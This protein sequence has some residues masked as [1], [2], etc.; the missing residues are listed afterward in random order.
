MFLIYLCY[1]YKLK[2]AF[3]NAQNS[4]EYS[5]RLLGIV[6]VMGANVGLSCFIRLLVAFDSKYS[7]IFRLIGPILFLIQLVV[8]MSPFLCTRKMSKLCK[9]YFSETKFALTVA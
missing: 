9:E 5:K 8:I 3:H 2:V 7:S 4:A 1:F 6:I